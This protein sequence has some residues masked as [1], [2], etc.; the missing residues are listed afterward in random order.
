MGWQHIHSNKITSTVVEM[1]YFHHYDV[2]PDNDDD[3][4]VDRP[5]THSY[6]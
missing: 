2:Y 6:F 1:V 3:V 5:C 4:D